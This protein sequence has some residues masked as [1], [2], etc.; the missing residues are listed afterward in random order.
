MENLYNNCR[1]NYWEKLKTLWQKENYWFWAN[2]PLSRCLQKTSAADASKC[3]YRLERVK[4]EKFVTFIP[5]FNHFTHGADA[6]I[7]AWKA[8][9]SFNCHNWFST[10]FQNSISIYWYI[11]NICLDIFKVVCYRFVVCGKEF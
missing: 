4:T 9:F 1:Y 6:N 8:F 5:S 10:L 11:S 2:S 3:V 7:V